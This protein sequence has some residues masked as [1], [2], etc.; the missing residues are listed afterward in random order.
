M[1]YIKSL[2]GSL[3]S[4]ISVGGDVSTSSISITKLSSFFIQP[5]TFT[6]GDYISFGGMFGRNAGINNV[7][8]YLYLSTG[9]TL[10]GAIQVGTRVIIAAQS[11][12]YLSRRL[13]IANNTGGGSGNN[14]GTQ[15]ISTGLNFVDDYRSSA[16]SQ[17]AVDWTSD[18]YFIV[19]GSV[20]NA[21][22]TITS[23]G[24]KVFKY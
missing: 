1:A 14:V 7:T 17:I 4:D 23:Y 21:A 13:Y 8:A 9:D 10:T 18:I 5:N 15:L 20:V 3:N 11:F 12:F 16:T 6:T 19:A 2:N 22:D 24:L